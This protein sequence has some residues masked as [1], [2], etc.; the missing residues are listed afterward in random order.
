MRHQSHEARSRSTCLDAG[1]Y[2][3]DKLPE[4]DQQITIAS[5]LRSRS[6]CSVCSFDSATST[7]KEDGHTQEQKLSVRTQYKNAAS[8]RIGYDAS[9]TVTVRST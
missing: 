6:N 2:D 3:G 7:S 5:L 4:I 9:S 1:F 8:H